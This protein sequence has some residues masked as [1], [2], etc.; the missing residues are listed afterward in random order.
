M[1]I[2][3]SAVSGGLDS[4][5]DP[6]FGRCQYFVIVDSENLEIEVISNVASGAMSGAG[7]QA[8]QTAANKGVEIVITGN[9]GPNAFQVLSSA[10]IKIVTG[11]SGTVREAVEK[12]KKGE[13]KEVTGPTV[14]GHFGRGGGRGR[15]RT[16][17]FS[18]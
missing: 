14:G 16:G 18:P 6:R 10:G 1:K 17:R 12:Y 7:V 13:L 5:I 9:V 4:Q 8:A 2:C 11:V 15:G 3:I